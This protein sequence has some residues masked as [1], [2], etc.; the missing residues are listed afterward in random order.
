[1]SRAADPLLR[2]VESYFRDH[3]QSVRGASR[4]T[5]R[6]YGH[7]LLLFLYFLARRRRCSVA[8][9]SLDDIGVEHVLAFLNHLED[10]RRQLR[11]T[12]G[13]T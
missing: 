4:H 6:A 9:L 11:I 7:A 2:L 5:V 13:S 10:E 3:L 8:A 1:L 12:S